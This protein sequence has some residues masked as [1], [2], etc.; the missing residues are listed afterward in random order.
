MKEGDL[1]DILS[2]L[3]P[4]VE[5]ETLLAYL[6]GKLSAEQQHEVERKVM[7]S[8]FEAEALEGLTE[9]SDKRQ[10]QRLV[11]NLNRDLKEKARRKKAV[12]DKLRLKE[13]PW[14]WMSVLILLLL[15]ILAFIVVFRY[16]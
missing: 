9:F 14:L 13:Q 11:D 12:R 15:V 4:D 1:K 7:E 16:S 10:L 5:Q 6:Q 2:H 3:N 8:D